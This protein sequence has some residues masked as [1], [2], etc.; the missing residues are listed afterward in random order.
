MR[1]R[2]VIVTVLGLLAIQL[3]SCQ[4]KS[5]DATLAG[6]FFPLKP[7]FT[8]TY[9]V[10]DE[11]RGTTEI[12]RDR[13]IAG[14]LARGPDVVGQVE[15]EY[16]SPVGILE[17]SIIYIPEHGY[18]TRRLTVKKGAWITAETAFLPQVLKPDLTWSNAL[19]P[20]G[21]EPG[22]FHV[23]QTHRTFFDSSPIDVPA[24]RFFSCIRVE[25]A[26]HY[27]SDSAANPPLEL[28]Y[29][30]WYAPHVGL[31][32][33]LVEHGGLFGSEMARVEL[34]SFRDTG[35]KSMPPPVTAS[36]AEVRRASDS[37]APR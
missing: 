31:V 14:S 9:R 6:A 23:T 21:D 13:A 19:A 20:F 17:S 30:D 33:T 11:G 7:G 10:V 37:L 25:T 15:S 1:T 22:V 24:G 34:L 35:M 12:L 16:S 32:K 36:R 8:W 2:F 28:K 5:F 18:F 4:R 27:Q 3:S 29:I 26:A